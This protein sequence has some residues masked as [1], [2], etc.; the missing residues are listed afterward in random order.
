MD[1]SSYAKKCYSSVSVQLLSNS[2]LLILLIVFILSIWK[3]I[4]A[5]VILLS[6]FLAA[7][8]IAKFW[9]HFSLK[10][11]NYERFLSEHRTFQ[12]ETVQ[13]IVRVSNRKL[14][15]LAWLD[16]DDKLPKELPVLKETNE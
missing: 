7:V 15:P 10:N 6:I 4:T 14:L 11:V 12:G 1:T 2:G 8:G 16:I 5:V 13:L 3:N 9:S